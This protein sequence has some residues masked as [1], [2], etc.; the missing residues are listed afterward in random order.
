M[1][2]TCVFANL[3]LTIMLR[4]NDGDNNGGGGDFILYIYF[5]FALIPGDSLHDAAE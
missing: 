2:F 4:N 5:F 3:Q 1:I